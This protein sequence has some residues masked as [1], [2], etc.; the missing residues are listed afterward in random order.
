MCHCTSR[1]VK[2]VRC[3]SSG[4]GARVSKV[5]RKQGDEAMLLLFLAAIVAGLL[6]VFVTAGS[7]SRRGSW[8]IH[9]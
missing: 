9:V 1:A 2:P 5:R 4:L 3:Y 7:L 8:R 6:R